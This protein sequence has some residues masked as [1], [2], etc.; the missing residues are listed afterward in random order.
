VSVN[1]ED[2]SRRASFSRLAGSPVRHPAPY[3]YRYGPAAAGVAGIAASVVVAD[4]V[5]IRRD[6]PTI[7]AAVADCLRNPWL[8]ALTFGVGGTLF[9]HLFIAPILDRIDAARS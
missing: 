7:S 1:R 3:W 9:W 2:R 5:A 6:K 8:G 4:V